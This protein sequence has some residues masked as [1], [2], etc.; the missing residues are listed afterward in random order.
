MNERQEK[1]LHLLEENGAISVRKLTSMLYASE[2]TVRRDLTSL[3]QAGALKRTHGGAIPVT[4]TNRQ[5]PLFLREA[6]NSEE[7]NELC[8]RAAEFVHD[9]DTVFLDGSSTAQYM[10]RHL[11]RFKDLVAVTYSLKTA[12]LLSDS[13][14]KTYCTGGLLL[15]NSLVFIGHR[16]AEF[17]NGINVDVCFMSCKGLSENGDLTD[18]SDEETPIRRAFLDRSRTRVFLMTANKIGKT[19]F[20]TLCRADEADAILTG[21]PLPA[22]IRTRNMECKS[23]D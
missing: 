3:E 20:H 7:K 22:G 4:D 9:G 1:I 23:E 2:A 14:I 11:R 10:V 13:H 12:G 19:Y 6:L 21:V 16:A 5:V 18:T 17:A 15:E 8:R